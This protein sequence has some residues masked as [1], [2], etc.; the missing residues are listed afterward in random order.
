M[1]KGFLII[2]FGVAV[3]LSILIMNLNANV[4][5][6]LDETLNFFNNTQARLISN[7][8][9]EIYLEKMRRDKEMRGT[10]TNNFL[11]Q[12]KYDIS[13]YGP[14][15]FMNI[16]SV[17]I[18]D[19]VEHTS[20]V[21]AR[22]RP[23]KI[24]TINS[25]LYIS[26]VTMSLLLNGN[27]DVNGNDHNMNGSPGAAAPLPGIGVDTPADSS[28]VINNVKPKISKTIEGYGGSPSVYTVNNTI[29]WQEITED[30]ISSADTVLPTGTYS[31]GSQFGTA[32][33][34]I[35]TYCNGNVDFTD[36]TG[37]GVMIVNGNLNLSGNFKFYGIVIV[38][39]TSKIRTQ[40]IGN[41]S[42]YGATIL[43]GQTVEI[44]SLGNAQFYYSKQAIDNAKLNLKS[45]K[46]EIM[47]WWE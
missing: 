3:T 10:F 17:A 23:M 30:F 26:A 44:S 46:F 29:N 40:T 21:T 41:N 5:Q 35:I 7:S 47:S 6:E 14:D 9:I 38:Y 25:A 28:F 34:P 36:A 32:A 24:P 18:Y 20:L 12:G 13:I 31:N 43:V 8:G 4:H 45:S 1:G 16:K 37:Y 15:S 33:N 11:L 27:V 39:G 22:R 19:E 2:V 42:I